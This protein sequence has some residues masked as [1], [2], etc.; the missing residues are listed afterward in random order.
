MALLRWAALSAAAIGPT[1]RSP[2]AK[3]CRRAP[4]T[5]FCMIETL[6]PSIK[7]RVAYRGRLESGRNVVRLTSNL[8]NG[9]AHKTSISDWVLAG[10]SATRVDCA[11]F[12]AIQE[13]AIW[14]VNAENTRV[15]VIWTSLQFFKLHAS[16]GKNEVLQIILRATIF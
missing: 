7:Q 15:L 1:A 16:P 2:D 10:N 5:P 6:Q 12:C 13:P 3:N 14:L 9:G 4:D 8:G 11:T